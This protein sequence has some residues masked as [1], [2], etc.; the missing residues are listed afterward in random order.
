MFRW[1]LSRERPVPKESEP[2]AL[3]AVSNFGHYGA[4]KRGT[5]RRPSASVGVAQGWRA[6]FMSF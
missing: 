2:A 1:N 4:P 6:T 3:P 5:R